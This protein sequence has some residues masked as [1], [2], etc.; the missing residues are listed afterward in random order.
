[1]AKWYEALQTVFDRITGNN[2]YVFACLGLL[3]V[4]VY[5]NSMDVPFYFDDYSY[6][7]NNPI[8]HTLGGVF[9]KDLIL[10]AKTDYDDVKM[11]VLTRPLPYFTFLSF[12]L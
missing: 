7:I 8:V 6:I 10:Q 12:Y 1:M 5:T 11:S 9:D 3:C 2:R 4:I